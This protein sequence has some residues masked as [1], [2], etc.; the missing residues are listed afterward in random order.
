MR[1]AILL[2]LLSPQFLLAGPTDTTI[3]GV[4]VQ[5]SYSAMIFPDTWQASP[6]S[7][8]GVPIADKEIK[9]SQLV[10]I[11]ALKKYPADVLRKNLEGVY[12]LRSMQFFGVG[13]GGTNSTANVYLTN[14]GDAL[15]YTD[16]Y[17]EQ[18]FH[19]EFSS[20]ILRNFSSK[21]DTTLWNKANDKKFFYNDPDRGVGAIRNNATSQ[22]I[23]T[24]ICK[25]G[26]LSEYAMSGLENDV[27]TFAQ[28][29]F[30]P[31]G[32]F[33]K[34]VDS[35]PAIRKKVALMIKLYQATSPVFT[36]EYFR[37]FSTK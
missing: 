3:N 12:F 8:S 26:M 37:K 7:A 17:L 20:I 23:D 14:D 34:I 6:I 30:Y 9:R 1:P 13:Y 18:T 2:F 29:L 10:I 27:N 5:F 32:N 31:S 16:S 11:K 22:E 25:L 36:E 4:K 35:Y 24:A 15:G 28:Y 19:H 33:W 21:L